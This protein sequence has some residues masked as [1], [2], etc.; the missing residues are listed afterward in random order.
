MNEMAY[1]MNTVVKMSYWELEG[2]IVLEKINLR[3]IGSPNVFIDTWFRYPLGWWASFWP[4]ARR[5]L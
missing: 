5:R 1:G 2:K 4:G 3:I